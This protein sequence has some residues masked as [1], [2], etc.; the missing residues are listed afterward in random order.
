MTVE[1]Q[2][3]E[4][5]GRTRRPPLALAAAGAGVAVLAVIP[6]VYLVVRS[7]EAFA[8]IPETLLRPRVGEL[9][10]NSVVLALAV[11][12]AC[13]VLGTASGWVLA[14]VRL[15]VRAAWLVLAALPLAVPSYLAAYGWLVAVPRLS[16][17]WPSWMVL[18]MACTPYVTL[19]VAAALRSSSGELES[20]AR[21]LGRHPL[22]AFL[23]V[24]WPRIAP[25]AL[26]GV[27]IALLYT[28]SDFGAV[29]MLRFETLTWGIHSA[30]SSAFDRSQ[31]ALL[32]VVLVLLAFAVVVSERRLR[33]RVPATPSRS[34]PASFPVRPSLAPL[35][36]ALAIV[37]LLG[38]VVPM[39]GLLARLLQAETLRE[40]DL[41]RFAAATA[42]TLALGAA[43]AALT[44]L[45]ALPVAALAARYRGALVSVVESLSFV[46]QALPGIVVGLSLVF[47]TLA[48][49]PALYQGVAALV[50]AYAVLFLPRAVGSVRSGLALV[51]PHLLDVSRSLG[52]GRIA[53]WARVTVPLALPSVGVAACLVA[54][55]VA[56]ELPATLLLRPTGVSTLATELWGR[57]EVAEY[58]AAAPYAAMLVL[59]AAVPAV[60]LSGVASTPREES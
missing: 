36:S 47:F 39:A 54:I 1:A 23:T 7:L 2:R 14:R 19:P 11:G 38:V 46:G 17:F 41:G 30:Y 24:T 49:V 29:S 48:V 3:T 20:V 42:S 55:S 22:Q 58:G 13:L 8:A 31:A 51:P 4:A 60:L 50:F 34:V 5:A 57:T 37:P 40:I 59:V 53:S 56:K 28:L 35:L 26:A 9:L 52:A 10:A 25:S 27:L 33:R 45:L 18:T 43:A 21:S 16:G 15:P 44:V 12:A 6:L 32:S